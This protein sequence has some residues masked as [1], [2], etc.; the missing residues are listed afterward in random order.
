MN[1]STLCTILVTFGPETPEFTTLT[2][3]PFAAIR[4]KSAPNI[5]ECPIPILTYFTGLLGV[6]VGMIFQV[7]VWR[8]SKGCCYGNQLNMGD[9]RKRPVEW[10]LLFASVFDNRLADRKSPFYRFNANNQGTSCPNLVNLRNFCRDLPTIWRRSSFVTLALENGLEDHN[11]DF[12]RIIISY[13]VHFVE[14]WWH[15]VLWPRSLRH[16]NLYSWR[17]NFFCGDFRY[18]QLGGARQGGNQ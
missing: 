7:F 4:Q 15:S 11:F 16:K 5:S 14:I 9:V 1:F 2:V 6:L 17:R 8:S 13:F 3:A 10:P 18:V 12:S